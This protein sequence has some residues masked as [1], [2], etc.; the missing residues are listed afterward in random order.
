MRYKHIKEFRV[1]LSDPR[2]S[3]NLKKAVAVKLNPAQRQQMN[4]L[5]ELDGFPT[6]PLPNDEVDHF[7]SRI[8]VAKLKWQMLT[9]F[10]L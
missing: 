2:K 1:K 8:H 6:P 4:K 9:G 3:E 7:Y 5:N 10:V